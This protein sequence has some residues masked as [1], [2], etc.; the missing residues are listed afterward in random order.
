MTFHRN[1]YRLK[2]SAND[3]LALSALDAKTTLRQE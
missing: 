1:V 2:R 3:D